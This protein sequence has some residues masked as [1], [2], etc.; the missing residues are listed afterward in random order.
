MKVTAFSIGFSPLLLGLR[1]TAAGWHVRILPTL[2]PKKGGE[3]EQG[4]LDF[5]F[6]GPG[7]EHETE[8]RVGLIPFGGYVALLGQEDVGAAE[9]TADPRAFTNKSFLARMAVILAGVTFNA[10]SA[11]II[12]MIIFHNGIRLQAPVVGDVVLN[13]PADK[14]GIMPGDEIVSIEGDAFI[15]FMN[16]ALAGALG[17]QNRPVDMVVRRTGPDETAETFPVSIVPASGQGSGL[18]RFIRGF[19]IMQSH[20]LE[21][22][23]LRDEED[24][25][26]LL[27]TTGLMP[28][29]TVIAVNGEPVADAVEY[30]NLVGRALAPE[31]LLTVERRDPETGSVSQ[32]ETS[33]ALEVGAV[34]PDFEH[35]FRL[36]S[37]LG[38]VPRMR[39]AGGMSDAL[40]MLRS[41]HPTKTPRSHE[42]EIEML[43]VEESLLPGDVILRV[44]QSDY[45]TFASLRAAMVEYDRTKAAHRKDPSIPFSEELE[46]TVLRPIEE[47]REVLSFKV[48]PI[49]SPEQ[50][51]ASLLGIVSVLD[52]EEA[53]VAQVVETAD[54]L[55]AQSIPAGAAITA[56]AGRQVESFYDV[57]TALRAGAGTIAV[58]EWHK[59]AERGVAEVLVPHDDKGITIR[60]ELV[61]VVPFDAFRK[62]YKADNPV[63]SIVM[64]WK[65]TGL[66]VQQAVVTITRLVG[67]DLS[68]RTLSGP[69]GIVKATYTIAQEGQFSFYFYWLGLISASIAVM[70]L[71]PLVPLDGG[72]ILVM[73]VEKIKG[74]PIS[75]RAQAVLSYGGWVF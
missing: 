36:N 65:R 46:V 64:G 23:P 50:G 53:V 31:V 13:S 25:E 32:F 72:I 63:Q 20:I 69:V 33:L 5:T 16:I 41:K 68:P 10:V 27:E 43:R 14:A 61:A 51:E 60:S 73:L 21:V 55:G 6:R 4:A 44:G 40:E 37:I 66:F 26:I 34:T 54:G 9:Q 28:K 42:Q 15:D 2:V 39:Y 7:K 45:P 62:L 3:P 8:Y 57:V 75:P 58:I 30:R 52:M 24:R 11:L 56:V 38:M 49:P 74:S 70:N 29:D 17:R 35:R 1:R 19:G 12:F 71:L 48:R 59:D 18:M 47:G 67:G 22:A